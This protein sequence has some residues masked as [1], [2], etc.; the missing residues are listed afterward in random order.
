MLVPCASFRVG[1]PLAC[2]LAIRIAA[3]SQIPSE[4]HTSGPVTF[5]SN[6][7]AI[8]LNGITNGRSDSCVTAGSIRYAKKTLQLEH[9]TIS[10]DGHTLICTYMWA[11]EPR[12]EVTVRHELSSQ[13]KATVWRRKVEISGPTNLETDLKVSL[14][15]WPCAEMQHA[16]LPLLNGIGCTVETNSVAGFRLA[17]VFPK[18]ALSLALPMASV[19]L[20]GE[21]KRILL[22]TDPYFST[23]FS[24]NRI[25]WIYPAR[26]GLEN[27]HEERE[28][29]TVIHK[30]GG[31]KSLDWFFRTTLPEIPAGPAWLH[32]I[33]LVDF[34]YMSGGGN[35]WFNDID[36]LSSALSRHDR[37]KAF[38]CMHGCYDFL[39]RYCYDSRTGKLDNE[40]TAFSN[41]ENARNAHPQGNIGGTPVSVGFLNCKPQKMSLAEE[42][43]RLRYARSHGF[44]VG[45]YFADGLNAGDAL[46]DFEASRVLHFGGWQGPDSKGKSYI[47][48]PLHPGVREFYLGYTKALLAEF[49]PDLDALVWDE[50]FHI[51][52]GTL[53]TESWPGY[54]DR[55]MM[56]LVQ[57]VTHLVD[58]YNHRHG[59]QIALLTSDSLGATYNPPHKAPYALVSH[60]T[61]QDSWCQPRAWSFGIF[62]NYQNVVWSCCWWPISKWDW[63]N[64]GVRNYQAPVSISNGWG[65]DTGFS[66]MTSAQRKRVLDL[67][68]W[69][70]KRPTRLAWFEHLPSEPH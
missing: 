67:F 27:G 24:S 20:A 37:G 60:G 19:P 17:G 31:E 68:E 23:L 33:A 1:V 44:R 45:M 9:P 58:E 26:P 64:F 63:V 50:T 12:I 69:R 66:E 42:H 11:D 7:A 53:G 46:P 16:W 25:E 52:C 40:W 21:N 51:P 61:Y 70:K 32:D 43:R 10:Q 48:N 38:F 4:F 28:L 62:P 35:G 39:G 59:R 30:G 8:Q 3:A 57:N 14:D 47:Q 22:A 29:L 13:R 6:G 5:N 18:N 49:G 36:A 54:A 65:D 41:Y 2:I 15:S 34:D 56:R 55:A